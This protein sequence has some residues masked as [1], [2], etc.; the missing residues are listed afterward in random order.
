MTRRRRR[1]GRQDG[2]A[3]LYA[4]VLSPVLLLSLALAVEASALQLQKQRLRNAVD[5]ATVVAASGTAQ[6]KVTGASL[7]SSHADG[8]VRVALVDNLIPLQG[9]IEGATAQDIARSAEVVIVTTVPSAD[10][11]DSGKV[12]A[13]PTL[14]VRVHMPVRTG[15]LQLAGVSAT[16]TLTVVASADL[17]V[18]GAGA[19]T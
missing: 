13:R 10:P 4:I 19:A 12:V 8:L 11:F 16:V 15:L 18:T 9:D 2:S 3:V 17:R 1:R 5:Q 7:D 6:T 14:E